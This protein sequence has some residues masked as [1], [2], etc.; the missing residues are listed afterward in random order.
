M[1]HQLQHASPGG[2]EGGRSSLTLVI[3]L[4]E[5]VMVFTVSMVTLWTIFSSMSL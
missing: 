5:E 1:S 3:P 4:T 2:G